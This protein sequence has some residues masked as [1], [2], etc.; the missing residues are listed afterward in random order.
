MTNLHVSQPV[1]CIIQGKMVQGA[2]E[3][4]VVINPADEQVL[5][6][7]SS[8][9][10]AQIEDT[11]RSAEQ[12]FH[13]WKNTDDATRQ[14][15]LHR[16]ADRIEE[17]REELARLVVQEQGKPYA[18]A[19]FEVGGAIAWTRYQ[20]ELKI[21]T[22]ILQDDANKRIE[23]H[24]R[25]L[26]VV[27]SVTPWNWPLMIAVWHI[28]PAI[29]AG[30][31]VINKPSEFTPLSTLRLGELI[32]QE[33]APGVVSILTG[34]GEVGANLTSHPAIAKVVFTGSTATGQRIMQNAAATFKHLTLELGGNDAGIVLPDT[35]IQA[36]ATR[37]FNGAFINM[38]QT[39]AALKRLYVHDSQYD[40]LAQELVKVAQQ[41]SLGDGLAETTTFGPVQN[42]KQYQKVQTM[43]QEAQD[44]GAIVMT[45]GQNLPDTGYFIA[46][47]IVTNVSPDSRLVQEEQFGP[48]LPLIRYHDIEEVLTEANNTDFG[49]GGS[50]WSSNLEQ[51]QQF[52][53]RLSC[54]TAWINTH[55]EIFPH[56]PFG[57][58]KHSGIGAQFGLSGLLEN[59]IQQVV[60]INK[61]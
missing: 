61:N 20:A 47:T 26:G 60:H 21:E 2:A 36:M 35:D 24:H 56:V 51:A 32:Q 4:F 10:E 50:I 39:C 25:P 31:V 54:G 15:I 1:G 17:H 37:I 6:L 38:G 28:M 27:A 44:E 53:Q 46:P 12:A 23:L 14:S 22:E 59:T 40:S 57:G 11:I 9:S 8:P 45:S 18:L 7:C 29:R 43:I 33:V 58:W 13:Q 30:N 52:A 49:L 34:G 19:E 3:S 5:A 16:I 48:V 55:G 42:I 41:Q